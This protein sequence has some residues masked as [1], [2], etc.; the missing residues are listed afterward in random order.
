M[1]GHDGGGDALRRIWGTSL[2]Y[3]RFFTRIKSAKRWNR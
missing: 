1:P 2:R 3:A